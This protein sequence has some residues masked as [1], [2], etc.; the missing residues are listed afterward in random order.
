LMNEIKSIDDISWMNFVSSW[1]FMN[2]FIDRFPFIHKNKYKRKHEI[3]TR[4]LS[5]CS[6]Y[7]SKVFGYNSSWLQACILISKWSL[8]SML[9]TQVMSD[10]DDAC[11]TRL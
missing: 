9:I 3:W 1:N 6:Q 2:L 5:I 8:I 7:V 10:D 11:G 4:N